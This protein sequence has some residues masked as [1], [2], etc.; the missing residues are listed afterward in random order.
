MAISLTTAGIVPRSLG[1]RSYG[2]FNF[3]SEFFHQL[4]TFFDMGSS[5]WLYTRLAH[6]H[7]ESGMVWFYARVALGIILAVAAV[8]VVAHL[9][10]WHTA[11]WPGQSLC[12]IYMAMLWGILNW[13]TRIANYLTDAYGLTVIAEKMKIVQKLV[14]MAFLLLL[15]FSQ[16]LTLTYYF[17][18]QYLLFVMIIGVG[19]VII[20]NSGYLTAAHLAA[21]P[22]SGQYFSE[23][24]RYSLPLLTH[25]LVCLGTTL[26]DRWLLQAYGGSIEQGYYGLSYQVATICVLFTSA[27]TPLFM[28]EFA[29]AFAGEDTEKMASLF[30]YVPML[31]SISAYFCCFIVT[32]SER[33]VA[34]LGGDSFRHASWPVL[35]MSFYPLAVTCGQLQDS[36]FYASGR[37][38]LYRNISI[39]VQLSGLPLTYWLIAPY[40]GYGLDLGAIGLALKTVFLAFVTINIQLWF[41]CRLVKLSFWRFFGQQIAIVALLSLWSW[42]ICS[43]INW[44]ITHPLSAFLLSGFLYTL[45]CLAL[46]WLIPGFFAVDRQQLRDLFHFRSWH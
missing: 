31:Y 22:A 29:I 32:Q 33:L 15:F 14:G 36:I 8:V 5:T 20:K 3:L 9:S 30:C 4:L 16:Y 44:L 11:I 7:N 18:Y 1:P 46:L 41:N 34:F 28:R 21:A 24:Y 23:C 26:L 10:A 2:N 40:Q 35:I 13:L 39:A 43:S 12:F 38:R 17:L 27:M 37:T 42:T 19:V 6:R 25:S 45:G